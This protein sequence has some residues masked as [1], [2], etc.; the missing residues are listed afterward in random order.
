MD[1]RAALQELADQIKKEILRRM[2]SPIGV[3]PRTG[4]NTLV[5][6]DL[7]KSVEVTA[8]DDTT[9]VFSILQHF[10]Y[11]VLGWKSTGRFPGTRAQFFL[12][13]IK[14][15]QR[16]GIEATNRNASW[17]PMSENTLAWYIMRNIFR[18]G[19]SRYT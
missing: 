9:L 18:H 10:E 4:T 14:W 19:I 12:N 8:I 5:D 2:E 6:S 16:K 3:N 7:Y 11:V 13:L 1:L 15:I 17:I